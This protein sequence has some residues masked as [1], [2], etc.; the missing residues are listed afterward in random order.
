MAVEEADSGGAQAG[1]AAGRERLDQETG[2]GSAEALLREKA[3]E[4]LKKY[5][6]DLVNCVV[7]NVQNKH[8][9]SAKLLIDLAEVMRPGRD[10]PPERYE[11]FAKELKNLAER[12]VTA[13]STDEE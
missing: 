13:N 12:G 5:L 7:T 3:D 2:P 11:S 1:E 6:T 10:V 4:A 9:A 8:L